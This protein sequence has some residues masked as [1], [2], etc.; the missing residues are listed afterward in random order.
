MNDS[1]GIALVPYLSEHFE[2]S[3][4]VHRIVTPALRLALIE[5]E[6]PDVVIEEIV[7]RNVR[8]PAETP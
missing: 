3:V 5:L 2:R 1:F 8:G 7:E 6:K 4:F